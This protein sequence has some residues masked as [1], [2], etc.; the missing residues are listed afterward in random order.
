MV[1]NFLRMVPTS[2]CMV[3]TQFRMVS[4]QSCWVGTQFWMVSTRFCWHSS[5]FGMVSTISKIVTYL[6]REVRTLQKRYVPF[7]IGTYHSKEVRTIPK[8]SRPSGRKLIGVPRDGFHAE[9]RRGT[10]MLAFNLRP[11][12][13]V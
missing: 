6:P 7:K 10:P 11:I 2:F 12:T 3:G 8:R 4:R 5:Q 1:R 13:L 9:T